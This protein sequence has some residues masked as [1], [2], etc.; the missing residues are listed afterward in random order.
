MQLDKFT[1]YGLR[2]LM[3][4]AVLEPEKVSVASIAQRFQV[5]EHHLSKVATKLAKGGYIQSERGRAGGL[6]LAKPADEISIGA[7]LRWLKQDE[8]IVE[9]FAAGNNCLITPACG[10][11]TPLQEAQEAFFAA[12]DSYSLQDVAKRRDTL[13][14]LLA[15]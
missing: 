4:L 14:N 6:R 7:V 1:D 3:T 12:L 13:E 11:R 10:L 8:P 15:V 5:S 9:C 2:I